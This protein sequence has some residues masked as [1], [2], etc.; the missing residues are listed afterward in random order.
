MPLRIVAILVLGSFCASAGTVLLKLG[1]TGRI[2]FLSFINPMII[3]GLGLYGLG[4]VFWIYGMSRQNL[5]SVYPFTILSFTIVYLVGILALGERPTRLGF[6]GVA[7][8]LAGLY[9]VARNAS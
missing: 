1:A 5:I 6:V 8:I 4:A 9:L 7:L 2:D 3:A